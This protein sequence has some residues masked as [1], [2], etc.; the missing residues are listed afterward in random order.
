[1]AIKD[2]RW[3]DD[4]FETQRAL[5][6][7]EKLDDEERESLSQSLI[8]IIKEIKSFHKEDLDEINNPQLSLGINR[9]M[10]L[11]QTS[12]GRRWYDKADGL[13]FAMR[14]MST[15]PETDFRN[16]MDGLSVTLSSSNR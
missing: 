12:N 3:Y 11:Y 5:K 1:M 8:S 6:L 9:V 7:L 10:G 16:I 2:R 13:G 14:S 4:H 15:L